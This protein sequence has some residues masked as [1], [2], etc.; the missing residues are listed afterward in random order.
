MSVRPFVLAALLAAGFA[1]A[2][3]AAP[4]A[5]TSYDE[6]NGSGVASSGSWNYWD[7]TYSGV[8]STTTDGAGLVGGLGKLTDG[9]IATDNWYNVSNN[10]G[11]GPHVGWRKETTP[12]L[13][14]QFFFTGSPLITSISIYADNSGAGGV[15]APA[16]V[17]IDG[18]LYAGPATIDGLQDVITISGLSLTGDEHT[19]GFT[20]RDPYPWVFVSEITFDGMSV[21]PIPE[22]MSLTLLGAGLAALGLIR[23]R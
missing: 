15:A 21:R 19:I 11:T 23:R 3:Q 4:V 2:T 13:A 18:T 7:V 16:F 17:S 5:P 12:A 8:G 6:P 9:V 1:G 14:I 22:P 20:Y 10:A